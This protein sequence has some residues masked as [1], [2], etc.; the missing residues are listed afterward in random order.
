MIHLLLAC[1][2]G[3]VTIDRDG[4]KGRDTGVGDT[5][6]GTPTDTDTQSETGTDTD[7]GEPATIDD[8]HASVHPEMES[9]IVLQWTQPAAATVKAEYSF[10]AGEWLATPEYSVAAGPRRL[11][12]LGAPFDSTVTWRLLVDGVPVQADASIDTERAPNGIPTLQSAEG[13]DGAWDPD[14]RWVL[15]SMTG[16]GGG[17]RPWTIITDRQGRTV[18]ANETESSRT[19]FAPRPSI[20]GTQ[21]LIDYNSWWG[22]FDGGGNGQ[23]VAFDIEGN[24]LERTDTPGLIHPFT[25]GADGTLVWSAA[26]GGTNYRGENLDILD[27][28]SPAELFDCNTFAHAQGGED[29][30]ANAVTWND[31]TGTWLYSL[32]T[33]DTVIELT[34]D[35]E[36]I[37]W[38]GHMDGAWSFADEDTTFWWQH[39]AQYLPDGHLILSSRR[40]ET[41]EE[42]V[43]REYEL[44]E[45]RQELV[46][47]WEFGEGEGV[48]ASILGEPRRLANGNTI[49]N[50]GDA[51]RIREATP[52]GDVVWD[53]SWRSAGTMGCSHPLGDL[54]P[55]WQDSP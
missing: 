32:Y 4:P 31:A 46:Q 3:T 38:F 37:R 9:I 33:L 27:G 12:L 8:L 50:Y 44:D 21:I 45:A 39:G 55:F 5:D 34:P 47:V 51:G 53:V 36:P 54:Y 17:A 28:G 14:T 35:G 48:Y 1:T 7:T 41:A 13:D 40:D 23:V 49:H 11:L 20:D 42:T 15:L 43:I 52:D 30:G 6:T 18:W 22:A 16:A 2:A 19:T 24:E 10:D 26:Q 29:C 25:Q